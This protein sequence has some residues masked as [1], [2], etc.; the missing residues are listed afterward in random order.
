MKFKYKK[1]VFSD[2][3]RVS[4]AKNVLT[5]MPNV[6]VIQFDWLDI[7]YLNRLERFCDFSY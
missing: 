4:L 2:E 7:G 3:E 1:S 5:G 6:E